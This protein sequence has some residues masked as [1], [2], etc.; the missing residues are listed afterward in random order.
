MGKKFWM[1]VG[2]QCQDLIQWHQTIHNA[3]HL[4][5]LQITGN[6]SV[7]YPSEDAVGRREGGS[8]RRHPAAHLGHDGGH[9]GG[10]QQGG[11][12]A[13][14]RPS[15]QQGARLI[16]TAPEWGVELEGMREYAG[17]ITPQKLAPS[18]DPIHIHGNLMTSLLE[19]IFS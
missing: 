14:V 4:P 3:I 17:P 9:T 10:P 15:Q 13:H 11:L 2:R 16:L 5:G 7:T 1:V 6:L 19:G 12:A 18:K 8:F